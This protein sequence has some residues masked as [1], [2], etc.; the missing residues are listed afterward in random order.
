MPAIAALL[1]LA[2]DARANGALPGSFGILLPAER[3]HDIVLATNFGMIISEDDGA[4]WTWTCEQ[5][6]TKLGYLY[7]VGPPP[8]Q[9]YYGLSPL[10]PLAYSDDGSCSWRW[11]GGALADR[12]ATDFFVDP[13]NAAR[14][15][16]V[17]RGVDDDGGVTPQAVY[18]SLDAGTTFGDTP[19]YTSSPEGVIVGIE[20]ARSDPNIVYIAMFMTP[21]RHPRLLRSHDGGRVWAERDIEAGVGPNESRILTVDRDDPDVLYLRV[22]GAGM[23]RVMVTR[24]AGATFS[25]GVTVTGSGS[26]LSAFLRMA[27][28]TVLVGALMGLTG[29]GMNGLAYRSNDGGRT[30]V[31]W[32]L[33]PQPR[34]MGLAE[35]DRVLYLAGKNYS[36]GWALATSRDEGMT[37]QPLSRYEDV[38]S[39]R[40]CAMAACSSDCDFVSMQAVWTKDVCTGALLDAGV[41]IDASADAGKPKPPRDGCVCA[42]AANAAASD[43]AASGLAALGLALALSRRRRRR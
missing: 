19:L 1:V 13:N 27:S 30:F 26:V 4:S 11:G 25:T 20:I 39:I 38:R 18:E 6:E 9:R 12:E 28:G 37:L 36:D 41:T 7:S 15:L 35:R 17:A 2:G 29:G 43:V 42:T 31:P 24:D 16:V 3:P 32:V 10:Q 33:D 23:E 5:L 34:L 14:V 22:I 40:S 8:N 21:G